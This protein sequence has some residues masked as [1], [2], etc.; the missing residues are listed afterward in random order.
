MSVLEQLDLV[1]EYFTE[2]H[3]KGEHPYTTVA[4][5]AIHKK[6]MD[7]IYAT[8]DSTGYP[9]KVWRDNKPW[10]DEN[11]NITKRSIIAYGTKSA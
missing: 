2:M 5:P 4:L 6:G 10:R 8:S 9:G 1:D 3:K 11:G 7:E